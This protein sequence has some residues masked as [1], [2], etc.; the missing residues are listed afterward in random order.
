MDLDLILQLLVLESLNRYEIMRRWR[1]KKRQKVKVEVASNTIIKNQ[2]VIIQT[3]S[4]RLETN[5]KQATESN[6]TES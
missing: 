5:Q 4:H 2:N 1:R 6:R 3:S